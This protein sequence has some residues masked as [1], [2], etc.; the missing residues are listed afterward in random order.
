MSTQRQTW[1][2]F[3]EFKCITSAVNQSCSAVPHRHIYSLSDSLYPGWRMG[4]CD[5]LSCAPLFY[6]GQKYSRSV[7]PICAAHTSNTDVTC[8]YCQKYRYFCFDLSLKL[9]SSIN[10][11]LYSSRTLLF[12]LPP[13]L[14]FPGCRVS[15]CQTACC[16]YVRVGLKDTKVQ[17]CQCHCSNTPSWTWSL[18][19]LLWITAPLYFTGNP[20]IFAFLTTLSSLCVCVCV[21]LHPH[22]QKMTK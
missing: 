3:T 8:H 18:T 4:G 1:R 6:I 5:M 11:T 16:V 17:I 21:Y 9:L 19:R 12:H 14:V 15:D 7:I 13:V 20:S 10:W 22:T 2:T